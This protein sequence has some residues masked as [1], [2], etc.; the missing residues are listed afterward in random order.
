MLCFLLRFGDSDDDWWAGLLGEPEK[1]GVCV[2]S[3]VFLLI[4]FILYPVFVY[5]Y[6]PL[7]LDG[8]DCLCW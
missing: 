2:F 5:I 1:H 7:P 3:W 6:M 8:V 4:S